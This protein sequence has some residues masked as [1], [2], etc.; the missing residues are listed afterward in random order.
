MTDPLCQSRATRGC[1][2]RSL[3]RR[4]VGVVHLVVIACED[5]RQPGRVEGEWA[6]IDGPSRSV[7]G[8]PS[9]N[10]RPAR[11]SPGTRPGEVDRSRTRPTP[12][13]A[14][15][16]ARRRRQGT[17][18][19]PAIHE[20]FEQRVPDA[21]HDHEQHRL[22]DRWR[23]SARSLCPLLEP[24]VGERVGPD[25]LQ[26][27]VQR[28]HQHQ[29]RRHAGGYRRRRSIGP[30]RNG[31][32][33][34]R[35]A[36]AEAVAHARTARPRTSR[37]RR[38]RTPRSCGMVSV[39]TVDVERPSRPRSRCRRTPTAEA[40]MRCHHAAAESAERQ[41]ARTGRVPAARSCRRSVRHQTAIRSL[42]GSTR[43]RSRNCHPRGGE[44]RAAWRS[45]KSYA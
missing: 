12:T 2:H 32:V 29:L 1:G 24:L 25:P 41:Q 35:V 22:A 8:S 26:W 19:Q 21:D 27:P 7:S 13:P 17:L 40:P 6:S 18:E 31:V 34:D 10:T 28:R 4:S 42:A 3:L 43:R 30:E 11:T 33:G 16:T 5:H 44:S 9:P 14:R 38:P 23:R 37:P 45:H 36:G 39:V 15:A 20:L